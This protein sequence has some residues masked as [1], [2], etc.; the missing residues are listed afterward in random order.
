MQYL[1]IRN[2]LSSVELADARNAVDRML[3]EHAA[4]APL[5][6]AD[7]GFASGARHSEGTGRQVCWRYT[8][9]YAK[10]LERLVFHPA[11]WGAVLELTNGKPQLRAGD[12]ICDDHR[13]NTPRGGFLHGA[14]EDYGR[15]SAV[16]QA[17]A[18]REGK[19]YCDNFA[20]FPYLDTVYPGD[21]GL[22]VLPGARPA[23]SELCASF[24]LTKS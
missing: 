5:D 14:R 23:L 11:W 9:F 2:A 10:C 22:A 24:H 20:V 7:A 18:A 15:E 17:G 19:L 13:L 8:A 12:L 4:G 3:A 1:I 16:L 21:G 6:A